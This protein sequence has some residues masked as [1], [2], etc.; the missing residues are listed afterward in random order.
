MTQKNHI[1]YEQFDKLPNEKKARKLMIE[2]LSK[3]PI[4]FNEFASEFPHEYGYIDIFLRLVDDG[5][6][7]SKVSEYHQTAFYGL[8]KEYREKLARGE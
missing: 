1:N 4:D 6:I 5:I 8:T 7:E 2:F 3:A